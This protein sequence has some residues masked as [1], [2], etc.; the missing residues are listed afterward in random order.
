LKNLNSRELHEAIDQALAEVSQRLAS[1]ELDHSGRYFTDEELK[2]GLTTCGDSLPA[3]P[4]KQT[5][6]H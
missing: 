6:S 1:G 5:T 3:T 4:E 2:A